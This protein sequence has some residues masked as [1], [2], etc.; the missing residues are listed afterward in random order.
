MRFVKCHSTKYQMKGPKMAF[1][2]QETPQLLQ[3]SQGVPVFSQALGD[4]KKMENLARCSKQ[5]T[6]PQSS[7]T[8]GVLSQ[9]P[10][11]PT[12]SFISLLQASL[13]ANKVIDNS[14][15]FCK[16]YNLKQLIYTNSLHKYI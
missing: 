2:I 10:I 3:G 6:P 13:R 16:T 11:F 15:C 12:F 4:L 9:P 5:L 7:K 14:T 8:Y 1:N